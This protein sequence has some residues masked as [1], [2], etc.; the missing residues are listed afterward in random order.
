[1]PRTKRP[2]IGQIEQGDKL[3]WRYP[4]GITERA[5]VLKVRSY[6]EESSAGPGVSFVDTAHKFRD[7]AFAWLTHWRGR[8]LP[9]VPFEPGVDSEFEQVEVEQTDLSLIKEE[10]QVA[11]KKAAA[12]PKMK[13]R[14]SL[15]EMS[16]SHRA[17]VERWDPHIEKLKAEFVWIAVSCLPG[18][19]VEGPHFVAIKRGAKDYAIVEYDTEK[20]TRPKVLDDGFETSSAMMEA[21]KEYRKLARTRRNDV[22]AKT[23]TKRPAKKAPAKKTATPRKRAAAKKPAPRKRPAPTAKRPTRKRAPAKAG[24]K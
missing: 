22:K 10:T 8:R 19:G 1:M 7:V 23:A 9:G 16:E 4:N 5:T 11:T 15:G 13:S 14:K 20:Q 17:H 12:M 24:K 6:P 3:R 21:F 18:R 2:E